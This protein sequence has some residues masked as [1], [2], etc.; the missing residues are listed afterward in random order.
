MNEFGI[1]ELVPEEE[2]TAEEPNETIPATEV[3][4]A[5]KELVSEPIVAPPTTE[6]DTIPQPAKPGI[7]SI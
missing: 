6:A 5:E 3:V 2:S 1:Y 4:S 7:P